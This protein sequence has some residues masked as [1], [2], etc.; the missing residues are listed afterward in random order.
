MPFLALLL[1]DRK[2]FATERH[3]RQKICTE[4]WDITE[5]LKV[6]RCLAYKLLVGPTVSSLDGRRLG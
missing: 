1:Q 6:K 3:P 5:Y 2:E 4:P